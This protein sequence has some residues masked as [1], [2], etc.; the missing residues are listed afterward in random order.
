M[1]YAVMKIQIDRQ[2]RKFMFA[3]FKLQKDKLQYIT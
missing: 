3:K 1:L 2:I